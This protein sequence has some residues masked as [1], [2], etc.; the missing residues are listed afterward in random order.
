MVFLSVL[1]DQEAVGIMCPLHQSPIRV[2][3]RSKSCDVKQ[4]FWFGG[5]SGVIVCINLSLC[6]SVL[7][8]ERGEARQ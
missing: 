4:I 6:Y 5:I 7:L 2:K 8:C 3:Q 1:G